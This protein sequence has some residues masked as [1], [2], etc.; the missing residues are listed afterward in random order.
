MR[1]I[2]ADVGICLLGRSRSS[3]SRRAVAVGSSGLKHISS[4]LFQTQRHVQCV[5]PA[6]HSPLRAP[7][8]TGLGCRH[9]LYTPHRH[10]VL[11]AFIRFIT[12]GPLPTY[13]MY[14]A[15]FACFARAQLPQWQS[16]A[17]M[18]VHPISASPISGLSVHWALC[19]HEPWCGMGQ[20]DLSWAAGMYAACMCVPEVPGVYLHYWSHITFTRPPCSCVAAGLRQECR[21][22]LLS[23]VCLFAAA[24]GRP[25]LPSVPQ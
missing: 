18:L 19:M 7:A 15:F 9:M 10:P 8:G 1:S 14:L 6:R 21:T 16:Q 3:S 11:F 12:R 20:T 5:V 24:L 25:S 13:A 22:V 23:R 4:C 17:V 2:W